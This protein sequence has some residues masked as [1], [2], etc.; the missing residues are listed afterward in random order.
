M[1]NVIYKI[2]NLLTADTY[3]GS[4]VDFLARKRQHLYDLRKNQHHCK[5]LQEHY[6]TLGEDKFLF[7]ILHDEI[8]P[9]LLLKREL[10]VIKRIKPIYNTYKTFHKTNKNARRR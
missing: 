3:I 8:R 7:C 4:A 5:L 1:K 6:N 2:E 10:N 9:S